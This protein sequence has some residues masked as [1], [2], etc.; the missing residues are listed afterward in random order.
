MATDSGEE[1]QGDGGKT[2]EGIM[3][4]ARDREMWREYLNGISE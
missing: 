4:M 3:L 2:W 1:N